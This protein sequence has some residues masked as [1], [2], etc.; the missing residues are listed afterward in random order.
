[1]RRISHIVVFFLCIAL[2]ACKEQQG[3][4]DALVRAEALVENDTDS[5]LAV[6]DSLGAYSSDFDRHLSMQYQL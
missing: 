1:M 4:R 6:L 5:A 2:Q 3:Y